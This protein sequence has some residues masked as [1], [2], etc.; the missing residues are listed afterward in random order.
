MDWQAWLTL[1][2]TV[3]AL[4]SLI[5]TRIAAHIV[6]MAVLS[7]LSLSGVLNPE[8][9]L[10]GFAN[11]GLITVAA[12][13]IVAAGVHASGGIDLLVEKVLGK[14]QGLRPALLRIFGPVVVLS[15]FLNNTPVV[16]TM[17]PAI[18]SW[19]RRINIAPSKLMIPLSYT[20]ILGGTL[21]L[22]GTSTN[23]VVNG[24]YQ[25]LTGQPG[26]SLFSI[27][28]V[29]LPVA[30]A[31]LV[32]MWLFFPRLLPQRGSEELVDNL[33]EFTL[34]VKVAANG[35]LVG[36]SIVD[37]GLRNL[38]RI[39]LVEI[40]RDGSIVTAVPSEEILRGGD[41][42]V[43]AGDTEAISDL[44]RINGIEP[45]DH[46]GES[47]SL[48]M[49]RPE[50]R[51]V[52]AVVSPHCEAIGKA[53]R[54]SR[55][56]DRY[57]AAILAVARNGERIKGNLGT[58]E[59]EA[60]DTLLLEARP[61]FVSRQRHNKDFL[62]ISD[63]GQDRPRH[64]RAWLSLAILVGIVGAAGLGWIS[65]LNASLIG[66]GLMIASRCCSVKQ[67]E[68]SLDLTVIVTIAASFALGSAIEKTGLAA[69]LAENIVALSDGRAWLILVL[70]YVTVSLL[71]E[72]ITNNAAAIIML[73]IVLGTAEQA[74]LNPE[75]FVFAIMM[76]ASA[77]FATPLGYQTNLMVYGPGDYRFS[78]FL[79]VGIPMNIF[80]G[81]VT[82]AVLMIGWPLELP[83]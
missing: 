26:L 72:T 39:Y 17:I 13:F 38:K 19:S 51:L 70:T 76:A 74:G 49:K 29:G 1:S 43:F 58:I 60:G 23:L 37:A 61:A 68:Q 56:R 82:L 28:L 3:S 41:R 57:G 44:L 42:L 40:E 63:L 81:A 11:G 78:D 48:S 33:R 6:M 16:A 10:A 15:A 45:S 83:R 32:F 4:L 59:L 31:G 54:D 52:E 66:A 24:Q 65:M 7:V 47:A 75:P 2:L 69:M 35:P 30:I 46:D 27:T 71:T 62:L 36:K 14:P 64:E 80:I 5:F 79:R 21:T 67:A 12:M 9:A 25:A 20:A 34:E 55:F 73:P 77:S 18:H 50:R 22:I 53:I 8:Q